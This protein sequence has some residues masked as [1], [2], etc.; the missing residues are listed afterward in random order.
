MQSVARF[1]VLLG[2]L[3]LSAAVPALSGPSARELEQNRRLLARWKEDPAHYA[4]LKAD[5]Q[6]FRALPPE[7]QA[8]LR[9]LD[10]E[11]HE[12]D[13]V[14][15]TQLW[16]V[17]DR[18][19]AWLDRLPPEQRARVLE[20]PTS[21]ERLRV[22]HDLREQEWEERLPKARRDQLAKAPPERRPALLA[23]FRQE[24]RERRLEWQFNA[25][26]P[27]LPGWRMPPTGLADLPPGV[28]A[29]VTVSLSPLLD[30]EEKE[31]LRKVEG[32]AFGRTLLELVEK[33][34]TGW[35]GPAVEPT[36][37]KDLPRELQDFVKELRG[38]AKRKIRLVEGSWPYFAMMVTEEYRAAHHGT[39]P[40]E[41]G[42]CRP[43]EFAP[44][45]QRFLKDDLPPK[46][47]EREKQRL[48]TAEGHWPEYP[49]EVLQLARHHGLRVPGLIPPG[50]RGYWER[51]RAA[52]ADDKV[53]R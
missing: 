3:T 52:V 42:P 13:P 51:L 28:H 25:G 41:L 2:V 44:A 53:T 45:L 14:I 46:L 32:P 23:D 35:P 22:I 33:H 18:Y 50:P 26:A 6:A 12:Q 9:Q 15:R 43:G 47:G 7:R 17:M 19:A 34:P 30:A 38:P 37:P 49:R 39:M 10:R 31:R 48:A 4:R 11:L 1:S 29:Y 24:E 5:L 36:R 8:S 27:E 40:Q 21:A 16:H 20:A